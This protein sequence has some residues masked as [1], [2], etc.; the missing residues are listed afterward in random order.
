M[1]ISDFENIPKRLLVG[2]DLESTEVD[3]KVDARPDRE[4]MEI[5]NHLRDAFE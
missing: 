1:Y 5:S 4:P 3:F 2:D